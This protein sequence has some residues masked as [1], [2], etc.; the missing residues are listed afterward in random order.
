MSLSGTASLPSVIS[1]R[2]GVVTTVRRRWGSAVEVAVSVDGESL[3]AIAYVDEVGDPVV[4]DR[5]VLNVGALSLGLGTGGHAI[6]VALP[7]RLPPDVAGLGHVIKARYT[8]SQVTVLSVDEEDSPHRSLVVDADDLAGMPV[9][10]ADLHS[11]LVPIVA[12][13][14]AEAPGLRVVYVMTDSAALP[15]AYSRAVAAL[16]E[17]GW[18]AGT[19]T[20]G[21]SYGGDLEAPTVH[22][23]LLAARHVLAADAVVLCPGPGNLGTGSRWGFSGVA[24]GEAVNAVSVLGGHPVAALRISSAEE[25]ERHQGVSHHSLTAYGRVALRAADVVVPALSG[26]FGQRV[27][28]QVAALTPPH[29]LVTV[30]ADDLLAVLDAAPI[31]ATTMGRTVGDDPEYFLANLAAGR[32]AAAVVSLR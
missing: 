12:A 25:R 5:V 27:T 20:C 13:L 24:V 22:M 21:Q 14:R 16:V 17:A 8:P 4:G 29:W 6:V 2:S 31:A 1:W 10:T 9:V 19:V 28:D 30:A 3:P 7:D 11:A 15:L 23:G 26:A 18:L 32:H